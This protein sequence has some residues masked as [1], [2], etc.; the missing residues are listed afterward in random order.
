M[1]DSDL[2]KIDYNQAI[3]NMFKEY[4]DFIKTSGIKTYF[5]HN[6]GSFDGYFLYKYLLNIEDYNSVSGADSIIDKQNKFIQ[7][8]LNKINFKDSYRIFGVSL[9][10]LCKNFGVEGKISKYN[11]EF[12]KITL[13]DNQDLLEQFKEYSIQDSVSLYYAMFNAQRIYFD[14]YQQDIT[15]VHSTSSLSMKIF[16]RHFLKDHKI[17]ILTHSQDQFIRQAYYGGSTDLYKAYA[18][19]LH[20]YDV[21]SLYPFAMMKPMPDKFICETNNINLVSFFG[22]IEAIIECPKTVSRPVLPIKPEDRTIYP[23]GKWKGVYF[24]E[25][26]KAV[27]KL[28]YI[29]TPIKG[30][31]FSKKNIF[32]DYI[33]HFYEQKK[34]STGSHRFIAKMHLNQLYGVFG[35]SLDQIST[36]NVHVNDLH[37]FM[38]KEIVDS[39]IQINHEIFVL[40]VKANCSPEWLKQFRSNVTETKNITNGVPSNVAIASAVTAYARIHM[41]PF[42]L[43]PSV[44]YTDTDSIF[45]TDKL[46]DNL[47]GKNLGLMK[48]ELD[49]LLIKEAIFLG[50]KKYGYYYYVNVFYFL[51]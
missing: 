19:D 21:N 36:I 34:N 37:M 46:G 14:N 51:V 29:V 48:D 6:L 22:F 27:A 49:G 10:K 24:S 33:N 17:P 5:I 15:Q 42:K 7:I 8:S 12:N 41:I 44:V 31:M 39:L 4:F 26:L 38:I 18:K 35:R 23:Y 16:R 32:D 47:I 40:L 13:F 25:E 11:P 3:I 50:I 1:V 43:N 28:G 2:L 9:D 45:T 30:F 20:Y